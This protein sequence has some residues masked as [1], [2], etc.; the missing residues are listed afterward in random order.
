MI[1]QIWAEEGAPQVKNALLRSLLRD[2]SSDELCDAAALVERGVCKYPMD[3]MPSTQNWSMNSYICSI[4]I[5]VL[6]TSGGVA[7]E[8]D[9]HEVLLRATMTS[10]QL[11]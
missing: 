10:H 1:P 7:P 9:C 11:P 8:M 5:V 3:L 4:H 2:S 6:P